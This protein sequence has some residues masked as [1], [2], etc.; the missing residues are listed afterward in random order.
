MMTANAE[1]SETNDENTI[2]RTVTPSYLG[3]RDLEMD[4]FGWIM[5][6]TMLI[7][8]LF[9]LPILIGIWIVWTIYHQLQRYL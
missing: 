8:L 5:F 4:A 3:R 2:L 9:L 6:L 7:V 1:E